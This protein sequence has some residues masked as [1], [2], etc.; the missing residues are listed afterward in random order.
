M[1]CETLYLLRRILEALGAPL[2]NLAAWARPSGEAQVFNY[3]H[4]RGAFRIS[5]DRNPNRAGAELVL[6]PGAFD[7]RQRAL[8]DKA[9][10]GE[11]AA[12]VVASDIPGERLPQEW[13]EVLGGLELAAVLLLERDPRLPRSAVL[14]PA[15]A[16]TEHEGSIIN[17]DG[18][19]QLVEPATQ[20]PR[21]VPQTHD[22]LQ[23]VL[24]LLGARR[25]KLS[26]RGLFE[27]LAEVVPA[28]EG[29]RR[30]DIG[31]HGRAFAEL[32]L[33]EAVT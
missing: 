30:S 9:R 16:F 17:E 23:E 10:A 6:G 32:G 27:E 33:Q 29:V 20:L 22:F 28:L 18:R 1:T 3:R 12:L 25:S 21:G 31:K 5:A 8:L 26:A 19:V 15:T 2:D 14:L 11:V 7:E 24:A 4:T 13:V